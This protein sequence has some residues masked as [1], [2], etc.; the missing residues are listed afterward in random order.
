MT[1]GGD[2]LHSIPHPVWDSR[3]LWSLADM[4]N[5]YL[6]S[7]LH[8]WNDLTRALAMA[9]HYAE[10]SDGFVNDKFHEGIQITGENVIKECEKLRLSD[11]TTA[12]WQLDHMFRARAFQQYKWS[13]LAHA[14]DRLHGDLSVALSGEYF[15]HYP[16]DEA[17]AVMSINAD[18][19]TVLSPAAF[20]SARREIEA[21]LD[22]Y[23]FA[24]YAGCVFHL[25]RAAELG[26]RTIAKERGI[27]SV[28]KNKPL[29]WGTW[30]DVFEA[31][32]KRL[33]EIRGKAAGPKRD[34]ALA[35]YDTSI[36]DLRMLQGL[37]RDP[38]MHFR[39]KYDKGEAYIAMFRV[40]SFMAMLATRLSEASPRRIR[41]G[42]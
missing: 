32:E 13:D 33:K 12:C 31:I 35:F 15:F 27:K 6:G 23:A 41:W 8:T 42:L 14:I 1:T 2:G 17:L 28:G 37:Y 9:R 16:S 39:D 25:M 30:K 11:T 22:C 36:S 24:D 34:A 21:A 20:P 3:R 19:E 7:F 40:R 38:T 26:L 29:E 10:Y 5:F 18:W 4:I